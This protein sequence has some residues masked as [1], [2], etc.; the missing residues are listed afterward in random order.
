MLCRLNSKLST[1]ICVPS[2][3]AKQDLESSCKASSSCV[4][5]RPCGSSLLINYKWLI[6]L[7]LPWWLSGKESAC[8]TGD[9]GL[10]PEL[11]R[12]PGEGND[13][14]LQYS[15][16]GDP[17]DREGWQATVHGVAKSWALLL[18]TPQQPSVHVCA[19]THVQLFA[20]PGL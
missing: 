13:N 19:L 12:S 17:M 8:Q 4:L 10:I 9:L 5:V 20:A 15:C 14:P 16:L 11:G 1:G 3:I 7:G 18:V 2:S 6:I